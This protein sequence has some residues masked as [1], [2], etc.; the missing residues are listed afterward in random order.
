MASTIKTLK[1]NSSVKDFIDAV[2]DEQ[3]R[4]DSYELIK[5]FESIT[6]EKASMR[7]TSI[8]GFGQYHYKSERSKQE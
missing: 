5:I 7:G 4:Q 3:K 2:E 8:I 6:K 1:N